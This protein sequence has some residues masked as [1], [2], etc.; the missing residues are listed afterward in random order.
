ME[1]VLSAKCAGNGVHLPG[2]CT[3]SAIKGFDLHVANE[4]RRYFISL[5]LTFIMLPSFASLTFVSRHCGVI[6]PMKTVSL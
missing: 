6:P 1:E 5:L 3:A 2:S 4:Q